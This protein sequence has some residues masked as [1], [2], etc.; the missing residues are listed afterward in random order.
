MIFGKGKKICKGETKTMK[1]ITVRLLTIFAVLLFATA[2][3]AQNQTNPGCYTADAIS[4]TATRVLIF[5]N[6]G[7][8]VVNFSGSYY[9]TGVPTTVSVS[10]QTGN[11]L[12]ATQTPFT[13]VS[14]LTDTTGA[15]FTEANGGERYWYVNVATLTGG[16]APT[17]VL[18]YCLR[19]V[20][21][22]SNNQ[23]ISANSSATLAAAITDETGTGAL[24]FATTPTL[25]TPVLGAATGT[26]ID[27]TSTIDVG[28]A[29][30][31]VGSV[32][33][34]NAT[35]GTITLS[36]VTGALGTVTV[37]VPAATDRLVARDT[38]DTL[39]NKT[40]TSPTLT[41]PAIGVAT[42]AS[43]ALTGASANIIVAGR[44]GTTDPSLKVD[45]SA[46][47]AATGIEIVSAAAAGGVNLRAISSGAAEAITINAKGTG[48]I[49]IAPTSTGAVTITPATTITGALTPTGGVAA[50]G[51]FSA[52]CRNFAAGG[53]VPAVS[54]DFTDATPVITETYISEVFVPANCSATGIAVFNGSNVT[55]NMNIGL[56]D[57]TG[58]VIAE[59]IDTAG[60][61]VDAYQRI[62]FT[63]AEALVGPATY[64]ILVQYSSAT[65]RYNSPPLGNHGAAVK[66]GEV[67]GTFTTI[68]PPTTFTANVSNIASL[69]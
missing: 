57:S 33:M 11:V 6:Q 68:T 5:T 13:K 14:A 55:G 34:H 52:S 65:A 16:T 27:L 1:R 49:G 63:V 41:T 47:T 8:G 25:V 53:L 60:S 39:T 67:F 37:S 28:V 30:T 44:Q 22:I 58:A 26:S 4:T 7:S 48:T 20:S 56:A 29:G 31:T 3:Q 35:S 54:T 9:T 59:S 10:I 2:T 18:S 17:L 45:A 21:V 66:V 69:Y 36:P 40:L 42:G 62:A 50:A 51:G 43:L 24:V 32:L 23:L 64:Y 19:P 46:A 61:G 15:Q 12:A 38:T